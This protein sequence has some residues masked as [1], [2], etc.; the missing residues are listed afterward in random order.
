MKRTSKIAIAMIAGLASVSAFAADMKASGFVNGQYTYNFSNSAVN[1]FY[2]PEAALILSK[3]SE[4]ANAMFVLPFTMTGG[5]A[6]TIGFTGAAAQAFVGYKYSNGFSWKLGQFEKMFGA[7]AIYASLSPLTTTSA[8]NNVYGITHTGLMLGYG[9]KG[10][11]LKFLLADNSLGVGGT[12]LWGAN[13]PDLGLRADIA[14]MFYVGGRYRFQASGANTD[15][16]VNAGIKMDGKP[17]AVGLDFA[18]R[19]TAAN[20]SGLGLSLLGTYA[21]SDMTDIAA[22]VEYLTGMTTAGVATSG[23]NNLLLNIGP[24]FKMTKDMR[25]EVN[26]NLTAPSP[27]S[28]THSADVSAVF[29]M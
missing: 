20:V 2:V 16:L 9:M 10:F 15:Y 11:N 3:D 13:G 18:L 5:A 21:A 23:Q 17:F 6:S 4:N 22:R 7:E 29:M 12:G 28:M 19:N 1:G 8:L 26:Y 25:V 27:G 24:A 14:D